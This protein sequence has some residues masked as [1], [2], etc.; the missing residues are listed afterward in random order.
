MV[1]D[2]LLTFRVSQ[3]WLLPVFCPMDPER[4]ARSQSVW[5][6]RSSIRWA[7]TT[8]DMQLSDP[9]LLPTVTALLKRLVTT[10]AT[11]ALQPDTD[12][13]KLFTKSRVAWPDA[14]HEGY[15]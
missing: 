1:V 5:T 2:G 6:W 15:L 13:G 3:L 14:A 7:K 12:S 11:S 10:S 9:G 4:F 8:G